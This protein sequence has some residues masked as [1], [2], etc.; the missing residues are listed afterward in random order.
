M[1]D[2]ERMKSVVSYDGNVAKERL[3]ELANKLEEMGFHRKA[4]SCMKLV[5]EIEAWQHRKP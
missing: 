2:Y 5:Y 4:Q 3:C 1:K